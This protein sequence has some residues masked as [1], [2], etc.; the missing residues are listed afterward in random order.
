MVPLHLVMWCAC[1]CMC[2]FVCGCLKV[3]VHVRRAAWSHENSANEGLLFTA[4]ALGQPRA[5]ARTRAEKHCPGSENVAENND[6]RPDV[7]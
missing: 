5:Q 2:H 6:S 7:C 1:V 3:C 4:G